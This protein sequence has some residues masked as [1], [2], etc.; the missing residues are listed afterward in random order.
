[1]RERIHTFSRFL[2][3]RWLYPETGTGFW[4]FKELNFHKYKNG[5]SNGTSKGEKNKTR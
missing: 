1:M 4:A 5:T 2:W 3:N